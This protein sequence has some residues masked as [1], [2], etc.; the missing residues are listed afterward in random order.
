MIG[1]SEFLQQVQ[2]DNPGFELKK[3]A[4]AYDF[5]CEAHKEQ[6]RKSGEPYAVHPI[7]VA[8]EVSK[9]NIDENSVIAALLHDV[10]EDT[11][12]TAKDIEMRFSKDVRNIVEGVTKFEKIQFQEKQARQVENF[13][14]PFLAK[15][16]TAD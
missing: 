4:E 9:I 5:C 14:K 7:S 6:K 10:V 13:R 11:K 1:K 3:I 16:L 8:L 2:R 12:Y 15:S